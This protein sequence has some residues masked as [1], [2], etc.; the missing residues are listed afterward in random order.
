V[1]S[2]PWPT[3]LRDEHPR[4]DTTIESL[5]K[6]KPAFRKDGTVTAGNASGINDGAALVLLGSETSGKTASR[7]HRRHRS[8]RL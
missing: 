1:R 2:S 5:A 3:W 6:L 4:A 7:T 8:G